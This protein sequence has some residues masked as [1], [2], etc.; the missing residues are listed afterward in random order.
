MLL[1]QKVQY[2]T[3]RVSG[4]DIF[5]REAGKRDLPTVLLMHGFPSSSH[6]FRRLIP[7]LAD[8]GFH[9]VAPDL[10]GFGYSSYP[11]VKDFKYSF[12]NYCEII[13]S[14]IEKMELKEFALY[15]HDYG[16]AIGMRVAL[17]HP[18][19]ITALIFQNGNSYEEGLG[20]E[21]DS[22]KQY[23]DNPTK[24]NKDK[25]PE[26]LN[27]E[28]TRQQY[29]AGVPENQ[30]AL[31][32]PDN[33]TLDWALMNRPGH[34]EA[35]FILFEDYRSNR[36]YFPKFQDFFRQN[37][38]PTLVIWGKF[39][40]YFSVAEAQ[41]YKH[42]IPDAETHIIEAGHKA[43]ESHFDEIAPIILD[44]LKRNI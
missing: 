10:P 18:G 26:W 9:V 21:W 29:L 2:N 17:K 32:S 15:L 3:L 14:F 7:F 31:F 43:L 39:D 1:E 12:E 42:D 37:Q 22:A 19:K 11:S 34:L 28:G 41:C 36:K 35:Q 4:L 33:W 20:K 13:S 8:E 25:L 24:E 30:V 27:E 40:V 44:F 38:L 16:S 23:W 5:Y 6:M